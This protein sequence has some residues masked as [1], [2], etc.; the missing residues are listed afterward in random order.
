MH[1]SPVLAFL[2]LPVG[3]FVLSL[4]PALYLFFTLSLVA[5]LSVHLRHRKYPIISIK[6]LAYIY[7]FLAAPYLAIS[8]LSLLIDILRAFLS[9]LPVPWINILIVEG[10]GMVLLLYDNFHFCKDHKTTKVDSTLSEAY[11]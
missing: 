4:C 5:V 8:L 10:L 1:S 3:L 9:T 6:K 7:A 11:D 2:P